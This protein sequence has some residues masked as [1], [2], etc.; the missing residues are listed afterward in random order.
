MV[1][2]LLFY[3]LKTNKADILSRKKQN[4]DRI[5][6]QLEQII[7]FFTAKQFAVLKKRQV[8]FH[9]DFGTGKTFLLQQKAKKIA[10]NEGEKIKF[11]VVPWLA[12]FSQYSTKST[13]L[14]KKIRAEMKDLKNVEVVKWRDLVDEVGAIQDGWN[15]R[16]SD[17]AS[18]LFPW[19]NLTS[20][21]QQLGRD[22]LH[23]RG[24]SS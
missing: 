9:T 15:K 23:D 4:T 1:K 14:E 22:G 24:Y 18:S 10:Q 6:Q 12:S 3:S 21:S 17:G 20:I 2:I 11:I 13:I 19:H 5:C 8:I 16:R 7:M